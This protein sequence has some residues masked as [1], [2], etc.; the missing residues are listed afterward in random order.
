MNE[1]KLPAGRRRGRPP[2]GSRSAAAGSLLGLLA[3]DAA[4]SPPSQP[5]D[6]GRPGH[7]EVRE[8]RASSRPFSF[9]SGPLMPVRS[10]SVIRQAK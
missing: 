9:S 1:T 3:F 8:R 7:Q 2:R 6:A 4:D 10:F 5:E